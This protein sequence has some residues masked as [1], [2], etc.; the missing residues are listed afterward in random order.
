MKKIIF[1][2]IP[3]ILAAGGKRPARDL[4][5]EPDDSRDVFRYLS[6]FEGD[7]Q[8]GYQPNRELAQTQLKAWEGEPPKEEDTE[9]YLSYLALLDASSGKSKAESLIK[10]YLTRHP[11][12]LRAVFLLGV[13]YLRIRKDELANY[14]FNQLEKSP[15]FVWKSLLY[16][17]LGMIALRDNN[18]DEAIGYFE[19][20][21]EAQP[22]IAA[23][24]ANLGSIYLKGRNYEKA[25]EVFKKAHEVDNQFEDAVLGLGSA[26]EGLGKFE[27][28][29]KQYED[30]SN[31][32]PKALS[33]VYNRSLIL[34]NRLNK[35]ADAAQL[36]LRYI[37]QGGKETAKAQKIMKKWR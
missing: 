1:L 13:H 19:K 29:S 4:A 3:F 2:L 27:E 12:E 9:Q 35:T 17:N 37:Q 34:G 23:P 11:R 32:H 26:L 30:F 14:F 20:A 28:A 24:L 16:N 25:Y 33:V 8:T 15:D 5:F 18:R 6:W 22:R 36:M 31:D 10:D 7:Y 21:T